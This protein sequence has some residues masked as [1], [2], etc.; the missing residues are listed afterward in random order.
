[1][2]NG[3]AMGFIV[4][5]WIA[6]AFALVSTTFSFLTSRKAHE[7]QMEIVREEYESSDDAPREN[8]PARMPLGL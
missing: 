4:M 3:I 1:M 2:P 7:R 6:F 5:S 8:R